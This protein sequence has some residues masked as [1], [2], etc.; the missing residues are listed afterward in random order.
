MTIQ[1]NADQQTACDKFADF[2][3]DDS[4][5][6][7]TLTG[8]SGRGKST[9][10]KALLELTENM[11]NLINVITSSIEDSPIALT[12][13]TKQ[14]ATVLGNKCDKPATTIHGLLKIYPKTDFTTGEQYLI[15]NKNFKPKENSIIF[16]DE[17]SMEGKRLYELINTNTHRCKVVRIGDRYQLPPVG[18]KEAPC[19]LNVDP[20]ASMELTIPQRFNSTSPIALLGDAYQQA[21]ITGKIPKIE[22]FIDGHVIKHC[23]GKQFQ[24]A[25]DYAFHEIP[26]PDQ[27]KILAYQNDTVMEYMQYVRKLQGFS[28]AISPGECLSSNNTY[29]GND[30]KIYLSNGET[31][32]V[33]EIREQEDIHYGL[34]GYVI[35]ARNH[36]RNFFVAKDNNE[37][38]RVIRRL[39]SH[40]NYRGVHELKNMF[41]DVR[42]PYASTVHKAQGMSI[43]DIY[44]DL[45]DIGRVKDLNMFLRMMY[46]AVTRAKNRIYLYGSLPPKY[47]G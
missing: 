26:D 43:N 21:L 4:K 46:V 37:L 20:D 22:N 47:R 45:N 6:Y 16:L 44:I 35:K 1:L 29:I 13:T 18:E 31:F 5:K 39:Q 8:G 34:D 33:Q 17:A 2:L 27:C 7:F 23:T 15:K 9:T 38:K 3:L 14:A 12:A 40:A 24:S 36:H 10:V 41:I 25:V 42:T 30:E 11:S 19:F 28:G 32:I